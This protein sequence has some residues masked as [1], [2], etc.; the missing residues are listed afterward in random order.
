MHKSVGFD[1]KRGDSFEA[2]IL[3]MFRPPIEV[4]PPVPAWQ[5]NLPLIKF[6]VKSSIKGV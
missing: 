2:S 5:S 6:L 3:A 4:E 1:Q